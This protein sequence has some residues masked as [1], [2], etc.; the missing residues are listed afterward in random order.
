MNCSI[1]QLASVE[2]GVR[3]LT[4]LPPERD[5]AGYI[6]ADGCEC[7][8][9]CC[10]RFQPDDQAGWQLRELMRRRRSTTPGGAGRKLKAFDGRAPGLATGLLARARL[11]MEIPQADQLLRP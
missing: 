6:H 9:G 7:V 8:S 10:K 4:K 5:G 11:E 1:K 2:Y 3:S